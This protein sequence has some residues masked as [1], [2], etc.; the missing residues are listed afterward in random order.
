MLPFYSEGPQS[1][2]ARDADTRQAKE[3]GPL[4]QSFINTFYPTCLTHVF[5]AIVISEI[6]NFPTSQYS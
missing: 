5:E 2:T 4:D 1:H 3:L 6:K